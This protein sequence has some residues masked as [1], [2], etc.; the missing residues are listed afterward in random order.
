MK[1]EKTII[2]SMVILISKLFIS[3]ILCADE[4]IATL[5]PNWKEKIPENVKNE[6]NIEELQK[7]LNSPEYFVRLYTIE[8]IASFNS[9]EAIDIL[10]NYYYS[11]TFAPGENPKILPASI[12]KKNIL[13]NT[14]QIKNKKDISS[15]ISILDRYVAGKLGGTAETQHA[16]SCVINKLPEEITNETAPLIKD[17]CK[18]YKNIS[19]VQKLYPYDL[20][21]IDLQS[22]LFLKKL[23]N[24]QQIKYLVSLM[25]QE[26]KLS[27]EEGAKNFRIY[28]MIERYPKETLN[29]CLKEILQNLPKE[30]HCYRLLNELQYKQQK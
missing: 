17:F 16:F 6:N 9:N 15:I 28:K 24:R 29:A 5:P 13:M 12:E 18:R 26:G 10:E 2:L 11:L 21:A 27:T 19:A 1:K 14:L 20:W 23:D 3:A 25:T 30:D 4:T 7:N 8:K 22:D